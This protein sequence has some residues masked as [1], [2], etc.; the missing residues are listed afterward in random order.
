MAIQQMILYSYIHNHKEKLSWDIAMIHAQ[1]YL[2]MY[3]GDGYVS[4]PL[5]LNYRLRGIC[6]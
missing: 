2:W 4:L 3:D 6:I 1:N 5:I